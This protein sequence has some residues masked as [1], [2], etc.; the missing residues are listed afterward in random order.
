MVY[1]LLYMWLDFV[2]Q[3]FVEDSCLYI[4]THYIIQRGDPA[5]M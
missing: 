3:Y 4:H 1:D 2:C 5:K